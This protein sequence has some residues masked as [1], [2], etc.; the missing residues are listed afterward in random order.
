MPWASS[1]AI[2]LDGKSVP[3]AIQVGG[4]Q[5][6]SADEVKALQAMID[7]PVGQYALLLA[8]T[9][10]GNKIWGSTSFENKDNYIRNILT[11]G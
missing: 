10:D 7:D 5:A 1:V 9:Q 6:T 8:G 11:G 2:G 4:T 3:Q